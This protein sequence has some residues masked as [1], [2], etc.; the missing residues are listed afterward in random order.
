MTPMLFAEAA[1]GVAPRYRLMTSRRRILMIE[2]QKHV[3]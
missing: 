1:R 3:A 2:A